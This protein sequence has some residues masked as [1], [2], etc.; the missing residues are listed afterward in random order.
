MNIDYIRR[1]Y[2]SEE[3]NE[4]NVNL[5]PI[6][7]F[8]DWFLEAVESKIEDINAMTLASST[9]GGI[10]SVR[11]VLLKHFDNTG[12]TFYTSYDSRKGTELKTNPVAAILFYW[13]ELNRQVRIEGKIEKTSGS[14]SDEYFNSRPVESQ[15]SA[16]ISPQSFIIESREYLE[17]KQKEY[18]SSNL[19]IQRP[20]NWGGFRL[21]PTYL[22]FWQGR[23]N[24]LHDRI[25]Y[26]LAGNNW[27]I[28]R[29]A[30]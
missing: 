16:I 30:P 4:R 12:F 23:P 27:R 25:V 18:K 1:E 26:E 7:Q 22:E 24:R 19:K 5:D 10:P 20:S 3:F 6:K 8:R 11:I 15:R 29:L 21:I 9:V 13:K 28:S 2:T 14:E 17:E